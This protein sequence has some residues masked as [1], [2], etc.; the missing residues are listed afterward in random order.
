M[1]RYYRFHLI[2]LLVLMILSCDKTDQHV[3]I[4]GCMYENA[5]NY[6]PEATANDDSCLYNDCIGVCGGDAV[7]DEC[8]VCDGNNISCED[9]QGIANGEAYL[10]CCGNCDINSTNNCI[11]DEDGTCQYDVQISVCEVEYVNS[12]E[13]IFTICADSPDYNIS[14]FQFSLDAPN[15]NITQVFLGDDAILANMENYDISGLSVLAFSLSSNSITSGS[16]LELALFRGT[17][18][19]PEGILRIIPTYG[20]NGSLSIAGSNNEELSIL[21]NIVDWSD[22]SN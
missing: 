10:D 15:F 12:N 3:F 7:F 14:G 21:A 5:C 4:E 1:F 20:E 18:I 2:S 19:S 6:N 8:D 13:A 22:I 17:Y 11:I 16:N 9:C